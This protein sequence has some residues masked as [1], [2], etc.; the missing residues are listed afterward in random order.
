MRNL[1][2]EGK[3]GIFKSLAISKINF[4]ALMSVIPKSI[5]DSIITLQ[6]SF[7]WV[8]T[9][10]RLRTKHYAMILKMVV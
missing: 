5:I 7:I 6:K 10:L 3:M 4:L 8:V 2:I 1:S 9:A